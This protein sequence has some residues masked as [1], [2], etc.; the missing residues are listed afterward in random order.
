MLH[1]VHALQRRNPRAP[2]ARVLAILFLSLLV[3]GMWLALSGQAKA[4]QGGYGATMAQRLLDHLDAGE[5]AKAEALFGSE[6]AK[7]VPADKLK[8]VWESLPAQTGKA[9]GRGEADISAQGDA[10]LVQVPLHY[11]KAELVAKL[12]IGADGKIAGF[13]IQPAQAAATAP[14]VADDASYEERGFDVG[15]GDRA[16]P[17]T[18]AMPK[19]DGPFPAIVLVHG[20]GPHDRDET[21][22]PN[23][24]F[25]DI[26]RGLVIPLPPS[27]TEPTVSGS[28]SRVLPSGIVTRT[29]PG[30]RVTPTTPRTWRCIGVG[31]PFSQV[32]SQT[33]TLSFSSTF[34]APSRGNGGG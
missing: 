32:T 1:I 7:A 13:L 24:P 8:A 19:G 34:V 33:T 3:L 22:G 5:Y 31:F 2:V 26:A 12:V 25:L 30:A 16:L 21:V 4:Q 11:E 6:M 28:L 20:S 10:T 27:L 14:A 18:L 23:K 29:V 15:D 9:T 17:G